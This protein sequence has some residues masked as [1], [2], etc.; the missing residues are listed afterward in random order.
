MEEVDDDDDDD[1]S[2]LSFG[3]EFSAVR[4]VD[5]NNE[6]LFSLSIVSQN[7]SVVVGT[8]D[9]LVRPYTLLDRQDDTFD[10]PVIIVVPVVDDDDDADADEEDF[11]PIPGP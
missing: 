7:S 4:L 2:G 3:K 8:E 11:T 9:E 6:C 5:D 10:V 1:N